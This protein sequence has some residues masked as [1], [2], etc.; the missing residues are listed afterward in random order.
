MNLGWRRQFSSEYFPVVIKIDRELSLIFKILHREVQLCPGRERFCESHS[1]CVIFCILS[2][3]T[4]ST[5][6]LMMN[7]VFPTLSSTDFEAQM[8]LFEISYF[9]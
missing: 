7:L 6:S 1:V 9:Y 8:L 2:K 3:S 5:I 4:A